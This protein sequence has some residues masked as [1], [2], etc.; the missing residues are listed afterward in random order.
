MVIA[1]EVEPA[2]Y[3]DARVNP[4]VT[5]ATEL[6]AA[7]LA[8]RC[9]VVIVHVGTDTIWPPR[10]PEATAALGLSLVD[11]TVTTV[12]PLMAGPV[13]RVL[14]VHTLALLSHA[15]PKLRTI[16]VA[17][18]DATVV[19]VEAPDVVVHVTIGGVAQQAKKAGGIGDGDCG[20]GGETGV[21]GLKGETHDE[22][23]LCA[24]VSCIWSQRSR[25]PTLKGDSA[26]QKASRYGRTNLI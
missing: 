3:A 18:N 11:C 10:E 4:T 13:V 5:T 24:R 26:T 14:K 21:G 2:V 8:V 9:A 16:V 7:K 25:S 17:V 15:L 6:E 20:R 23:S 1:D 12:E 22:G 19:E